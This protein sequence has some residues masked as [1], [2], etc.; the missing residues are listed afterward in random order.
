MRSFAYYVLALVAV[1][2]LMLGS[3]LHIVTGTIV[4]PLGSPPRRVFRVLLPSET[5][6]IPASQHFIRSLTTWDY[7]GLRRLWWERASVGEPPTERV[8]YG[9]NADGLQ[10]TSS[11][12]P[13]F[14]VDGTE[15]VDIGIIN[16]LR[17]LIE[18]DRMF[19]DGKEVAKIPPETKRVFV[20]LS[21]TWLLVTSEGKSILAMEVQP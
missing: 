7:Y 15:A 10:V 21:N 13:V 8:L 4:D 9:G 12:G 19:F 16:G 20:S 5:P 18:R 6:H 2:G 3:K 11:V 17:L 1:C 14:S